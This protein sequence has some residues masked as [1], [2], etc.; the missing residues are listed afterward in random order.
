MH[1]LHARLPKNFVLEERLERFADFIEPAP[2]TLKGHWAEAC[3]PSLGIVNDF[4]DVLHNTNKCPSEHSNNKPPRFDAVHLDLGC[5]KGV[6]TC[7]I[8]AMHPNILFI[9]MDAEPICIAYAAQH[10]SKVKLDNVIFVPGD[11]AKLSQYFSTNEISCIYLNFPTPFPRK[12]ECVKRLTHAH[13]LDSYRE[14]LMPTGV[15]RLKTDS[16]PLYSF[17]LTQLE[18]AGYELH[19]QSNNVRE[20]LPN[21]PATG[22]ERR[23]TAQG[24][25]VHGYEIVPGPRPQSIE[26]DMSMSLID[27]L[28]E[29]LSELDYIPHGMQGTVTNLRN[30]QLRSQ[31]KHV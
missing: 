22:Y 29:D 17:S 8:A 27:Y 18:P 31:N 7:D 21:D 11:A 5:G 24:A 13:M 9:G 12:K 20:M 16:I 28:P 10:A 14:I 26:L 4:E 6:F 3:Y 25:T 1:A 19:W 15:V 23:L 30:K 2:W